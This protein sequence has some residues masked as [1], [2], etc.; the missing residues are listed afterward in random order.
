MT[1]STRTSVPARRR[2]HLPTSSVARRPPSPGPSS[3][4][5]KTLAGHSFSRIAV[6]APRA[7]GS[8]SPSGAP[9][10]TWNPLGALLGWL[11]SWF[12][13]GDAEDHA[14]PAP[15]AAAAPP[16]PA[17]PA[18]SSSPATPPTPSAASSS[19]PAS[20]SSASAAATAP[21]PELDRATAAASVLRKFGPDGRPTLQQIEDHLTSTY[22][23]G[24]TLPKNLHPV[25][26]EA[27]SLAETQRSHRPQS[28]AA[29]AAP[30]SSSSASSSS[31]SGPQ[32]AGY[33]LDG[34][35]PKPSAALSEHKTGME[36]YATFV[37]HL[38]AGC[39]PLEAA[40][41]LGDSNVKKLQG[42]V[43][44]YEARLSRSH[45]VTFSFDSKH[46]TVQIHQAG[47]HT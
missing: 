13:D 46:K 6:D 19:S 40:R 26:Q 3:V 43:D 45:R 31:S 39:H 25:L 1:R 36:A 30:A 23:D 5:R 28:S 34:S 33:T 11:R 4:G 38:E 18:L 32:P 35:A 15:A 21:K 20:S 10:Q 17:A 27:R 24:H 8:G 14:T 9:I 37:R 22:G 2:G 7:G 47:G 44:Q 12:H 41:A 16:A 29:A 42:G